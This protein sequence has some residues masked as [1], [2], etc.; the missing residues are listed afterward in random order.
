MEWTR[1]PA[2]S[3]VDRSAPE[4]ERDSQLNK[5]A[6]IL[7]YAAA[8]DRTGNGQVVMP[9]DNLLASVLATLFEQLD[10][11]PAFAHDASL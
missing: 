2:S 11:I 6:R 10:T 9:I 8:I 4:R 5:P 7:R 3:L 1:L